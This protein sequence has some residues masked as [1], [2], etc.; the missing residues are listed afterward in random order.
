M[1]DIVHV[2]RRVPDMGTVQQAAELYGLSP[3]YIRRLCKFG[4]VRYVNCGNRWLVNL[5]SLARYFEQG[6]EL[7]E[8]AD[9]APVY[10][11]RQ[12]VTR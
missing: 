3:R 8:Q 11:I 2:A 1:Q 6:E 9:A 4:K 12:I 7:T 10:G 5:D